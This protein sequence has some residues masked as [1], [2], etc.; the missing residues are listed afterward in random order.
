MGPGNIL[1]FRKG[2]AGS[3]D[4]WNMDGEVPPVPTEESLPHHDSRVSFA[5]PPA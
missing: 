5:A 2:E 3:K 1:R 4:A